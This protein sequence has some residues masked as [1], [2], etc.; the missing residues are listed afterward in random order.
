M[1][2]VFRIWG[3]SHRAN[4]KQGRSHSFHFLTVGN[5][6]ILA[7]CK[8]KG[9]HRGEGGLLCVY[10]ESWDRA[11]TCKHLYRGQLLVLKVVTLIFTFLI[12]L[13]PPSNTWSALWSLVKKSWI[14]AINVWLGAIICIGKLF[15]FINY[16]VFLEQTDAGGA[17]WTCLYLTVMGP[18]VF[19]TSNSEN[20]HK[21]RHS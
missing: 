3:D 17:N 1:D 15:G 18:N 19:L 20:S 8:T 9:R 7:E 16:R 4:K 10:T 2:W 21:L 12:P 14:P 11:G 13:T 6:H 5:E